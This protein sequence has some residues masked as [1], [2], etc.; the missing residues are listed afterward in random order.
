MLTLHS[1]IQLKVILVR[2]LRV[3][4]FQYENTDM[5]TDSDL[6]VGVTLGLL[7]VARLRGGGQGG[8]RLNKY[9]I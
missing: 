9:W 5:T 3:A 1:T 6:F 7:A 8:R 4:V 2:E